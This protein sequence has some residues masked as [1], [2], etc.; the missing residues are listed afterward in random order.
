MH[1]VITPEQAAE[2]RRLWAD[3]Y[4]AM[5]RILVAIRSEGGAEAALSR[6]VSEDA[7]ARRAIARLKEL[8]GID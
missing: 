7:T 4:E 3:Y 1:E 2:E 5:E 6:V 8:R